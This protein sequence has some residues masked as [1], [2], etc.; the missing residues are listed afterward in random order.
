MAAAQQALRFAADAAR[1]KR[2]KL[3]AAIAGAEGGEEA[4]RRLDADGCAYTLPEFVAEYGGSVQQP[5]KEWFLE[6]R[7][8]HDGQAYT[9]ED[10][11]RE[12]GGSKQ[13]PPR[14]WAAAL[15]LSDL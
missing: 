11:V 1:Q 10:F 9:L 3:G 6:R 12:Y 15:D 7:L 8:D 4:E 14:Q 13:K 2:R 5:P